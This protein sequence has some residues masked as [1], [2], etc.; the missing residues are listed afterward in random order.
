MPTAFALQH[1]PCETLGAIA[2][3]L[4]AAGIT[5]QSI[6][7]F[8]GEPVPEAMDDAVALIVM[9]GPMGV[10]EYARYPFL[11]REM[12][13]IE[14]AL[15]AKKPVLGVCLGS[16]LLAAALGA[17]VKAGAQKEIGWYPVT[18]TPSAGE[19]PLWQG[20][21]AGFTA[22]LW[23]GDVFPLPQGAVRL[24]S[25]ALTDI[26]AFRHGGCAYGLLF[27][28]EVTEAMIRGMV[29]AFSEELRQAHVDGDEIIASAPAHLAT[30]RRIGASVFQ[31]WTRLIGQRSGERTSREV[32]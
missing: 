12:R 28:L 15:R 2:D 14:Q 30:L 13:L 31:R 21:E 6:R 1:H 7:T 23:H 25:S 16:Q 24:A 17:T 19:D 27:H 5:A 22:F 10:Y 32:A 26:Q 4:S 9:G 20:L 18:L 29:S 3:A 11:R 8:A